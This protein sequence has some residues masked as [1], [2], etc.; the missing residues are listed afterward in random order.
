[1][2]QEEDRFHVINIDEEMR[3]RGMT[4]PEFHFWSEGDG[5]TD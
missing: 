4:V 3:A 2:D 5:C 1:M